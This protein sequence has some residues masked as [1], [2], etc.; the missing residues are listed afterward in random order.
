MTKVITYSSDIILLNAARTNAI[1]IPPGNYFANFGP[2]NPGINNPDT[3]YLHSSYPL[4]SSAFLN[5]IK[6]WENVIDVDYQSGTSAN[7]IN[8]TYWNTSLG[9][10][11]RGAGTTFSTTTNF[12][13]AT[14]FEIFINQNPD[15]L[16]EKNTTPSYDNWGNW[17]IAHEIGHTL[18]GSGHPSPIG[19]L[20]MSIMSNPV[21]LSPPNPVSIPTDVKIPLTPGMQDIRDLQFGVK[22]PDG[23]VKI[24]ALG[25][26]TTSNGNDSYDFK[27]VTLLSVTTGTVKLGTANTFTVG[28]VAL[29]ATPVLPINIAPKDAVMTIYDSNGSDTINAADVTSSVYI[30]LNE[31]QF[32]S[33][34]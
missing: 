32:S 24:A 8:F 14:K 12:A 30:N 28:G 25:P 18:I 6:M 23:T 17:V 21:L 11:S 19:D 33:I 29:P 1:P 2:P 31:G 5:A 4:T 16:G 7:Q 22:N 3:N 9:G 26:S 13:A 15:Q 34:G 27:Q 20:R 10:S